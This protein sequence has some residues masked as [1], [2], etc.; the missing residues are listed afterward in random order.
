[1]G[2]GSLEKLHRGSLGKGNAPEDSGRRQERACQAKT[3]KQSV[4]ENW[5]HLKKTKEGV[6]GTGKRIYRNN[7]ETVTLNLWSIQN[8]GDL[9]CVWVAGSYNHSVMG[10]FIMLEMLRTLVK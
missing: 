2:E 4:W 7:S 9:A 3:S 6:K 5:V 1:M 10:Y 8:H